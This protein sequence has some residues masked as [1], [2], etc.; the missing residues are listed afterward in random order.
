I[1]ASP[2]PPVPDMPLGLFVADEPAAVSP[3][4]RAVV[5]PLGPRLAGAEVVP[6]RSEVPFCSQAAPSA[7]ALTAA[8]AAIVIF[9]MCLLQCQQCHPAV[10][11]GTRAGEQPPAQH[12]QG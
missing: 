9:F 8:S 2:A 11:D 1:P 5:P 6:P 4:A 10:P 3:G 7:S 12:M